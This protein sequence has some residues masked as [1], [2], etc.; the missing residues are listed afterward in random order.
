MARTRQTARKSTGGKAPRKE[1]ATKAARKSRGVKKS[2]TT[3]R[4]MVTTRNLAE[5][6]NKFAVIKEKQSSGQ[7]T[8]KFRIAL[9]N[10]LVEKEIENI[11][12]TTPA[13]SNPSQLQEDNFKKGR[14]VNCRYVCKFVV[15]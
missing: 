3:R 12:E 13:N 11:Q 10:R 5:K 7:K 6:E 4:E 15:I 9:G 8:P 1:L 14:N 2:R